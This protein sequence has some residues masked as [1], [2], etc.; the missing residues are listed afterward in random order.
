MNTRTKKTNI[1]T[2]T[3]RIVFDRDN[4]CCILCGD[5]VYEGLANAHIVP[6]SKGGLGIE[7][8]IV[9]LCPECHRA[10]DQSV[11]RKEIESQIIEYITSIYP[12]WSKNDMIYRKGQL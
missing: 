6:R 9:T 5:P 10:F 4:G 8:N 1:Q 2:K 3:K 12:N 7:Q 11:K